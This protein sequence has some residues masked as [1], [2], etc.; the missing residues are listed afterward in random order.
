MTG[1]SRISRAAA[2]ERRAA[3]K[4][5]ALHCKICLPCSRAGKGK[6]A[7]SCREGA[8]LAKHAELMARQEELLKSPPNSEMVQDTLF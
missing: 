5:V 1:R 2:A 6:C 7:A 3:D 4:A 8:A